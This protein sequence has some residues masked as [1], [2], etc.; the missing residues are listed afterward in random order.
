VHEFEFVPVQG[1]RGGIM[2]QGCGGGRQRGEAQIVGVAR[3][4]ALLLQWLKDQWPGA[5]AGPGIPCRGAALCFDR[6]KQRRGKKVGDD[7]RG[8]R[9]SG[10]G[11]AG[12]GITSRRGREKA[13]RAGSR[14]WACGSSGAVAGL[15]VGLG[16]LRR[17]AAAVAG[18]T[19]RQAG[20]GSGSR[21]RLRASRP[22][23]FSWPS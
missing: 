4:H 22:A 13:K 11:D 7:K 21:A 6:V 8:P 14:S 1:N 20:R 2:V 12:V 15:L 5:G 16:Q 18:K 23:R 19:A 10:C 17:W 3:I 9:V